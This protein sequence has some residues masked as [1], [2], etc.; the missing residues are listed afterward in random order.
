MPNYMTVEDYHKT[1]GKTRQFKVKR[2]DHEHQEQVKLFEWASY[3]PELELLFAIPNGGAR[4]I[5]VAKKLKAEGVKAGVPDICLPV[6]TAD[7]NG[8]FIELKAKGGALSENQLWWI[9]RLNTIGYKAVKCNGFEEAKQV[10]LDY[11]SM[12]E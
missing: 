8:L 11:L 1:F 2:V 4:H 9:G 7:Y 10:I 12:K 6:P 5:V 3:I